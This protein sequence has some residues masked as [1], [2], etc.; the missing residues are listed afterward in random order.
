MSYARIIDASDR[1]LL[2]HDR[3]PTSVAAE[4]ISDVPGPARP[5]FVGPSRISQQGAAHA[6]ELSLASG[7]NAVSLRRVGDSTERHQRHPVKRCLQVL[8]ET[9][10]RHR[11]TVPVWCVHF[12]GPGM[13]PAGEAD[14]VDITGNRQTIGN[15]SSLRRADRTRHTIVARQF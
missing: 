7:Q 15:F 12:Q 4:A 5:R 11:R 14:I 2:G 13:R 9:H 10:I 8:D 6:N 1:D 3:A